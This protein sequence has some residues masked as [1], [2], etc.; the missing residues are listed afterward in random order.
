M[1]N[2]QPP[3]IE[4]G[5]S[6]LSCQCSEHVALVLAFMEVVR[7]LAPGGRGGGARTYALV[8]REPQLHGPQTALRP[9]C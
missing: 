7:I 1:K 9:R 5:A 4:L 6:D 3:G 8:N 2:W